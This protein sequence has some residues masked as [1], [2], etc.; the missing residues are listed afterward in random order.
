MKILPAFN[1][2]MQLFPYFSANIMFHI[3]FHM[4][5]ENRRS[6]GITKVIT[7]SQ[8]TLRLSDERQNLN[9]QDL[10]FGNNLRVEGFIK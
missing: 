3:H 10:L 9:V 1:N 7:A 6:R 8:S 4:K 5:N 2:W